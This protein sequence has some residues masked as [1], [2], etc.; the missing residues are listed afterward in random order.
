L[1]IFIWSAVASAARHRFG[2]FDRVEPK[3]G[4]K[5]VALLLY[6]GLE[7]KFNMIEGS[8][9]SFALR[10]PAFDFSV[11]YER[12]IQSGALLLYQGFGF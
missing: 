7:F 1:T 6:E 3:I 9:A 11:Q 2:S 12:R 8:K 10:C 4:S 5:A